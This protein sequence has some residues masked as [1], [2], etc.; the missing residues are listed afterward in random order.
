MQVN[1]LGKDVLCDGFRLQNSK[2]CVPFP[3]C[4][5][6]LLENPSSRM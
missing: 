6:W 3:F 4:L 5:N 2:V 1:N